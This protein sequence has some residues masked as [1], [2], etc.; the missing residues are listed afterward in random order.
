MSGDKEWVRNLGKR[1]RKREKKRNKKNRKIKKRKKN[2]K[3][4]RRER[5]RTRRDSN[6]HFGNILQMTTGD[7]SCRKENT[8]I[9]LVFSK[10]RKSVKDS[11]L[12]NINV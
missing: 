8:T 9:L 2:R 7:A 3:K 5:K 12:I 1:K 4:K 10:W 6:A 11:S